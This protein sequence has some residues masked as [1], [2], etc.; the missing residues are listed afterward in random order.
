MLDESVSQQPPKIV[1]PFLLI[2]LANS[3][4]TLPVISSLFPKVIFGFF[5]TSLCPAVLNLCTGK[6]SSTLH[7]LALKPNGIFKFFNS[8]EIFSIISKETQAATT[9]SQLEFL[10]F[11]TTS[12]IVSPDGSLPFFLMCRPTNT[13]FFKF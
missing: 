3:Q 9:P 1:A 4:N 6:G 5:P 7:R 12:V 10:Y 2:F 11:L 8:S 13:V